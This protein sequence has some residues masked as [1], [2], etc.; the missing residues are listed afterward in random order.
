MHSLAKE[1]GVAY[2]TARNVVKEITWKRKEAA[3]LTLISLTPYLDTNTGEFGR[4][5]QARSPLR[6]RLKRL[7][8]VETVRR[9]YHLF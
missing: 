8:G 4:R 2:A 6:P 7:S 9:I 1:Y 5:E 3:W